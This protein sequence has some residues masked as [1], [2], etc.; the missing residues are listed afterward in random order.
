MADYTRRA[1][2]TMVTDMFQ[3]SNNNLRWVLLY[4]LVTPDL[5]VIIGKHCMRIIFEPYSGVLQAVPV[6][7]TIDQKGYIIF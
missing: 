7:G 4:M 5:Q 3:E 1:E 6:G 2:F